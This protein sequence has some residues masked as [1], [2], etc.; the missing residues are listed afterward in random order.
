MR[1]VIDPYLITVPSE[2]HPDAEEIL[3]FAKRLQRW[4][5]EFPKSKGKYVIPGRAWEEIVNCG[6]APYHQ[7]LRELFQAAD[8]SD[9]SAIDFLSNCCGNLS[10]METL[11][12][13]T[14]ADGLQYDVD[15]ISGTEA[16]IPEELRRRIKPEKVG[17]GFVTSLLLA[18]YATQVYEK[19]SEWNIATA[20]Y[21]PVDGESDRTLSVSANLEH[22]DGTT[23]NV[24]GDWSL[25]M[26]PE[27]EYLGR[28]ISD[29]YR[30]DPRGATYIAWWNLRTSQSIKLKGLQCYDFSFGPRF[31]ASLL[32]SR[33]RRR[34]TVTKDIE[35]VFEAIVKV[36]ENLWKIP[37]DKHHPLRNTIN[38][39]T[40]DQQTRKCGDAVDR[41]MRVEVSGGSECLHLHYWLC[42]DGSYEFS[43]ITY[44]HDDATI[45]G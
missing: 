13:V 45:Y 11:E 15:L 29:C 39:R 27:Y 1:I 5:S 3:A 4:D 41:A 9:Y 40:E 37:S 20:L 34:P 35:R 12:E 32:D 19:P 25:L 2:Q 43:N 17:V 6:L 23:L 14:G 10:N 28:S 22:I 36:L 26:D 31:V 33:M 7:T 38:N 18:Q 24:R 21:I 44:E 8:I 30:N 42:D 16:V